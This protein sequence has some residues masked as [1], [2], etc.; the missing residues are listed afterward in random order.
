M[1]ATG[2]VPEP[3]CAEIDLSRIAANAHILKAHAGAARLMA[4]VKANAYGHGAEQVARTA[5]ENGASWLGVARVSEAV[6]LREAGIEAPIL[7]L[8]VTTEA[9]V[10]LLIRYALRQA[11]VDAGHAR[12]LSQAAERLGGKVL[13]HIKVDTGMGRVGFDAVQ[14]PG[15]ASARACASAIL[16]AAALPGLQAEGI[17][18][19]FAT[20]DEANLVEAR[21]QL[22]R[23]TSVLDDLKAR[24]LVFELRHAANTAGIFTLP[25]ARFDM[26]RG[27]ISLYG[28]NPSAKVRVDALGVRPAM[29]VKG[30][31][32]QVK[33]VK[34]GAFI[35]YGGTWR[36]EQETVVA[37]VPCGYGDGYPRLLSGRGHMLVRGR[38]VPVLGRVCMDMTMVDVTGIDGVAVGDEVVIMGSQ[39]DA[40]VSAD[41][42]AEAIG[43][44]NYEVT[45][46]VASRVPRIYLP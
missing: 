34:K 39:G 30:N 12:M 21:N 18:T 44:I 8:G 13:G 43:T 9:G 1:T 32:V 6:A 3:I 24:G 7:I 40:T 10:P 19:H 17:F 20:A 31:I 38:R 33:H 22:A 42:I 16:E 45:C 2:N 15:E 4:V 25:E 23:F 46:M 5:L 28:M 29:T 26:V 36:A 11:V 35:S 41:E 37:T 27:G 14:D